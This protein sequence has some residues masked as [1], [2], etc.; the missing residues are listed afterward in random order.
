[1]TQSNTRNMALQGLKVIEMGQL[2]AGPFASKL[3]G[4]FGADV[5]KIEPPGVGDPLRKWRKIK[6]G[7]SL[8]W[9][10]QSRNKRSLTLDLKQT[11]AQEIV[12]K[13]VS[14]ADV[15]VENFRP[16]TL[17]GWGLSY[18]ALKA[19]NPRLIMLRISGY[20]QTGPYRDL[21]GFGVIGEA[22]GGLRHLSG[23]PGQAPVR[24]GISI[25]DSLSSLYGVI[26]V[27]LALQERA[28]SGEGQEIDVALYESVFAM[29]ESLIPEYDA[30]GYVREPAGSALP[31]ITPSNSYPCNDGSYV[32]IAGNGDSI[33]KRLM[34]LIGRDDLGNDPRLAQNDGRSQHAELIDGAIAEWTT[35]RGRDEVIE[36]LKSARVPAGY[37]YTAADIVSDPH[38]LA[39]QMIEQVQTSVG[40]LKVPGVLP[41]LSRTPGRIGTGGPQLGEHNDDILAGLGLSA[42]QVAGLR[43]RGII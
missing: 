16:G 13:L 42:E 28:R 11:E 19:I 6:D 14:E 39:R 5:I 25:G 34:S 38:Y 1:M 23:Y 7:T 21:P 31:G 24:V 40:P 36:A 37:P 12:R 22:M 3:L 18:E 41:K 15:L 8:W 26:G 27:L 30:F 4:E 33:Y 9:H 20:G 10:V 32:L 35:Q 43:E 17:E 2:I 29:M